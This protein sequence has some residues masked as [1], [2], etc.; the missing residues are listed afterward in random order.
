VHI[1]DLATAQTPGLAQRAHVEVW[2]ER[3]HEAHTLDLGRPR[4]VLGQNHCNVVEPGG[5]PDLRIVEGASYINDA[6][7]RAIAA[8]V[9]VPGVPEQLVWIVSNARGDVLELLDADGN[10]LSYR[11]Y[12]PYGELTNTDSQAAGSLS[13]TQTAAIRDT[14]KLRYAGYVYDDE[15]GLY[16]CSARYYDPITCQFISKDPARADGEESAYQYCGGDPVGKVDS[17]GLFPHNF[18]PDAWKDQTAYFL[19][20][21]RVNAG[22]AYRM[23]RVL[24]PAVFGAWWIN[25]VREKGAWDF[26]RCADKSRRS[27]KD[28]RFL[29]R[30]IS[31]EQFGNIHYGYVGRAARIPLAALSAASAGVDFASNRRSFSVNEAHDQV[32]IAVGFAL[33][34][35]FGKKVRPP[36]RIDRYRYPGYP[37]A[38]Y[39]V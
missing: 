13:A 20:V 34:R 16:Y 35:V 38:R 22:R 18:V 12:A 27:R 15:S 3:I 39:G 17:T 25:A 21:L 28:F 32:D 19:R 8:F 23:R 26:K 11:H 33:F 14:V 37:T 24:P 1:D 10:A 4:Q 7:G 30:K 6:A 5:R 2:G 36:W 9:S 29:G 31:M